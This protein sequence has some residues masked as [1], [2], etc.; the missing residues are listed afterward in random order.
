V[1]LE[2]TLMYSTWTQGI[3]TVLRQIVVVNAP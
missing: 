2:A 3:E 1:V